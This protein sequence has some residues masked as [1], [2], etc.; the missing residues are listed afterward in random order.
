LGQNYVMFN[1]CVISVLIYACESW[2][3]T[4]TLKNKLIAFESKCLRRMITNS[5]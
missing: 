1:A 3:S 5:N 4:K 2:K